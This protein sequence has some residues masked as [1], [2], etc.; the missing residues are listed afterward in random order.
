MAGACGYIFFIK[1]L[2]GIQPSALLG[3]QGPAGFSALAQPGLRVSLPQVARAG[4]PPTGAHS[5]PP[6]PS[7]SPRRVDC[8]GGPARPRGGEEAAAWQTGSPGHQARARLLP[9]EGKAQD[10]SPTA[11]TALTTA[12]PDSTPLEGAV[13]ATEPRGRLPV[14]PTPAP[15][16]PGSLL[17]RGLSQG[18]SS[19]PRNR[20]RGVSPAPGPE[21]MFAGGCFVG[22]AASGLG[23]GLSALTKCGGPET[24]GSH[25]AGPS[26]EAVLGGP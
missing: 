7:A 26:P 20:V 19:H 15:Q 23:R 22:S 6:A 5:P 10:S 4:A 12:T 2:A 9:R 17:R 13:G 1:S 3:A 24:P 11:A 21:G 14:P 18:P 25:G 8:V 16:G